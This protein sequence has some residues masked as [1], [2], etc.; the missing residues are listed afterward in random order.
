MKT[1]TLLKALKTAA[2]ALHHR[3]FIPILTHFCFADDHVF[4]YDDK[5]AVV[6]FEETG[7]KCAVPGRTLLQMLD[8]AGDEVDV[9]QEKNEV[10][11]KDGKSLM[12][13]PILAGDSFVFEMPDVESGYEIE[14]DDAL[15]SALEFCAV[16]ASTES[17][18]PEF[19][20]VTVSL[21]KGQPLSLYASDNLTCTRIT[22]KTK[23][24]KTLQVTIPKTSAELISKVYRDLKEDLDS[25]SLLI[26][27]NHIVATYSDK[28]SARPVCVVCKI[29]A[30][31]PPDV[32]KQLQQHLKDVTY[33]ET[34]TGLEQALRRCAV[35]LS[36][37]LSQHCSMQ[38][39][40]AELV[41]KAKGGVGQ[42]EAKLPGK[43]IKGVKELLIH[44][45]HLLRSLPQCQQLALTE[46]V[47][48]V[49]GG[50]DWV[51]DQV[52]ATFQENE[53]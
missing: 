12:R 43:K 37:E 6:V 3:D 11:I 41:I 5:T 34:P 44:P 13:L 10:V 49:R 42:V 27:E 31:K 51:L 46:S 1:K 52:I 25:A 18:R 4:A 17:L 30:I 8:G 14:M 9:K 19:L 35:V 23:A 33:F 47:V 40:S 50:E 16:C 24:Q 53:Q 15:V 28:D 20:G 38:A 7:L 21:R 36:L 32:E 29:L 26:S 48:A 45:P 39:V 2:P 22:T